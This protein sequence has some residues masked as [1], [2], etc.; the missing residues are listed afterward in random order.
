MADEE[1]RFETQT[2]EEDSGDVTG[3]RIYA[4]GTV[5]NVKNDEVV[6]TEKIEPPP[7]D[8]EGGEEGEQAEEGNTDAT[9]EDL[10][11]D[12]QKSSDDALLNTGLEADAMV[13]AHVETAKR[14]T[15]SRG[16]RAQ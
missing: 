4:D 15:R 2:V 13:D 1:L 11:D 8:E 10:R 6:E 12:L 3:Q 14:G 7:V 5:E 16:K 9:S